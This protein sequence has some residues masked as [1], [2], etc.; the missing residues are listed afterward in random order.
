MLFVMLLLIVVAGLLLYRDRL[1]D[2]DATVTAAGSTEMVQEEP[3]TEETSGSSEEESNGV[4]VVVGV[5]GT[6]GVGLSI[7]EDG[8]LVYDQ[9]TSPG[10]SEEFRAEEA[11][12]VTAAEGDAVQV[13]V[14]NENPE[15]RS[16]SGEW[17][18]RTFT[19]EPQSSSD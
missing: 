16:T 10:F 1:K 3:T 14:G 19:T 12:N 7:R 2:R 15:P 8:Q 5:V 13:A 18:T 11:I 17:T 4:R 6:R 9:V